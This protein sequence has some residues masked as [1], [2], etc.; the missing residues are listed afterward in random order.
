MGGRDGGD[1]LRQR[2][3]TIQQNLTHVGNR[4]LGRSTQRKRVEW[5]LSP[6]SKKTTCAVVG[7]P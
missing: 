1:D 3:N 7:S 2:S 4:R 5:D 6:E